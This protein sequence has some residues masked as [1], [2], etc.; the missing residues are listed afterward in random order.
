MSIVRQGSRTL[1]G[2]AYNV[3]ATT[4]LAEELRGGVREHEAGLSTVCYELFEPLFC[5]KNT[6]NMTYF[7][8]LKEVK[9]LKVPN[10]LSDT[11]QITREW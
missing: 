6:K 1:S 8:G 5:L 4:T 2:G 9:D 3:L 10:N 7:P 11:Q